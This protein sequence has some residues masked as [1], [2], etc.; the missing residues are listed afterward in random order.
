MP[1]IVL[2]VRAFLRGRRRQFLITAVLIG[3]IAGAIIGLAA[4]ARRTSSAPDRFTAQA[5]GDPDLVVFQM[6][7]SPLTDQIA[8]IPGVADAGS[9]AF[10]ASFLVS[11][12]DGSPVTEPNP[13][14]GDDRLLG[15]TLVEGRFTDPAAPNEFTANRPFAELLADRFGTTVGDVFQ[16]ASF[17]QTQL[18][19]PSFDFS[20]A[21]GIAPFD[22]TFVGI[23][24]STS[25][26]D[27]PSPQM[28]FSKSFLAAHPT[29]AVVQ[30]MVAVHL[31][32]G[33]DP[34]AVMNAVRQLPDGENAFN[35]PTR[36][37]SASSR[38]AVSFQTSALLL[39]TAIAL[40]AG[41]VVI[42][43]LVGRMLRVLDNERSP[44]TAIGWRRRDIAAE[45]AIEGMATAVVAAPV[46]IAVGAAVTAA[47]PLGVLREFEPDAGTRTDWS[48]TSAGIGVMVVFVVAIATI[49]GF[50]RPRVP[51]R[52]NADRWTN[53]IAK[54]GAGMPLTTGAQIT[55]HGPTG[56][57]RSLGSMVVAALGFA[58]LI[59]AGIVGLSLTRI[60]DQP[61]RWGVN[62]DQLFGNPYVPMY[63]D[64]TAPFLSDADVAAVT[65]A[66][67]GSVTLDGLDVA[68]IAVDP[69]LG[70]L[71]PTSLDGRAPTAADEIGLGAEVARRLG[72]GVGDSVDAVGSTGVS[73]VL[74]VVGIVVTPDSA[75]NGAAMT[76]DGFGALNPTATRNIVLVDF[77]EGAPTDIAEQVAG[78]AYTPPDALVKPT[79]I[80][81]LQR[82]TTAPFVLVVVL[83]GLLLV[84]CGY[85]LSTSLRAHRRELAVLR[86]LGAD[87]RQLRAAIHW[88]ATLTAAVVVALGVPIGLI[89]GRWVVHRLTTALGIVPGADVPI[90]LLLGSVVAAF[91][92]AN[93]LALSPAARGA[94]ANVH[95]LAVDR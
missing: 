58:G 52:N 22:A 90:G 19:D 5:G 7:G 75:G 85:L 84:A 17:D 35:A 20:G 4:G 88:H 10:V 67:I 69:L 30:T 23:T 51:A 44:L 43:L 89:V 94:R 73:E 33:T 16:V 42:S 45:R 66:A 18:S 80:R 93:L 48:A 72:V 83:A 24:R 27:D 56:S 64:I 3:L 59:A 38:R 9:I 34:E 39:V 86:A 57:G 15:T 81:A 47:F 87:S 77:R 62:Y 8:A 55:A 26:F 41:G 25:E 31:E 65:A 32:P 60:V 53:S 82:V 6:Q 61:D 12:I 29:A 76:F 50:Q 1:P 28:V 63:D 70:D 68:T 95:D 14:A 78:A 11:P 40:M 2:R 79:S 49:A 74:E 92:T 91:A 46:A 37:V 13:F 21:P 71:R 54:V 36:V